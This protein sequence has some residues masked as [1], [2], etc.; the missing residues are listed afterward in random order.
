LKTEL[1]AKTTSVTSG[2]TVVELWHDG[3][4]IGTIV[5][6]YGPGVRIIANNL[7]TAT[8]MPDDGTG[9][10]VLEVGIEREKA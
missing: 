10:R 1:R 6:A 8:P 2:Q 3:E 7:I 4:L 5:G 9:V